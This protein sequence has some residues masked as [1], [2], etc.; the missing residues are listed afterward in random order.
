MDYK[1]NSEIRIHQVILKSIQLH[2]T[3]HWT[4]RVKMSGAQ[5]S[6]GA[7]SLYKEMMRE[8][9]KFQDFNFRSGKQ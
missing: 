3:N 7:L 5:F 1:I 2:T 6:R 8:A 9:A 4:E